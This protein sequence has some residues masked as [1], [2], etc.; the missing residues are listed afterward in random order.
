MA[1]Y[2]GKKPQFPNH[3]MYIVDG[4]RPP[5]METLAGVEPETRGLTLSLWPHGEFHA[6]SG[7]YGWEFRRGSTGLCSLGDGYYYVSCDG[8]DDNGWYTKV[9]LYRWDGL[10]PLSPVEG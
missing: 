2:R 9:R 3:A 6:A 1:V 7:V 5:R 10:A 4:A 8:R